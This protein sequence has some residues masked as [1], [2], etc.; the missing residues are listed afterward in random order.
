[1]LKN[2]ILETLSK[3]YFSF[4]YILIFFYFSF[5]I[6]KE[7]GAFRN[8]LFFLTF[9]VINGSG[10][11]YFLHQFIFH[12][13]PKAKRNKQ[14]HFAIDDLLYDYPKDAKRFAMPLSAIIS[15][16]IFFYFLFFAFFNDSLKLYLFYSGF[17]FGHLIFEMMYYV[18]NHHNFKK[19]MLKK[20]SN[21]IF[22]NIVLILF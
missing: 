2:D 12:F 18:I 13:E 8:C 19:P 22:Y 16:T 1:M 10:T 4:S 14:W 15:L 9:G 3:V 21:L 7:G 11:D 6:L 5:I 20:I 17:I